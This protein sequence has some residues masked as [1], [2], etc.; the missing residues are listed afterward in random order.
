MN[1]K[2]VAVK[3]NK[4]DMK[5]AKRLYL[6]A[7][8]SEERAPFFMLKQKNGKNSVWLKITADGKNAGFF[9]LIT[10]N[11]AVYLCYFAIAPAYRGRHIGTKALKMLLDKYKGKRVFLAIERTDENA[12]NMD[13]RIK[14][15]NFYL[16]CGLRESHKLVQEGNMKYELLVH[17]GEVNNNDY[18]PM[19]RKWLGFPLS[20]FVKTKIIE[21]RQS[22]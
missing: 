1:I 11:D 12:D 8:P 4:Q 16:R 19:M 6:S 13:E 9:Y 20:C 2:I 3:N 5:W 14:R 22:V 21:V 7:F 10:N 17:G 15:K 18:E